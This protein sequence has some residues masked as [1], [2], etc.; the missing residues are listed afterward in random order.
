MGVKLRFILVVLFAVSFI[1]NANEID[2]QCRSKWG[3]GYEMVLYCV[4][5]QSFAKSNLTVDLKI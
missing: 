3:T 5:N 1:A 4:Q 2:S